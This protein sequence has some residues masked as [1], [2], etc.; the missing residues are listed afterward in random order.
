V[1]LR[2]GGTYYLTYHRYVAAEQVLA[3]HP[4]F[5]DF[6]REKRLRD[7]YER[8]ASDWYRHYPQLF[9]GKLGHRRAQSGCTTQ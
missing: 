1:A 5:L 8:F 6:L 9:A 2:F 7:P 3:A 4:R